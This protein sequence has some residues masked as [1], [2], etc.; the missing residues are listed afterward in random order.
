MEPIKDS[1][2]LKLKDDKYN[3]PESIIFC[4]NIY[5]YFYKN[6]TI[7]KNTKILNKY[8]KKNDRVDLEQLKNIMNRYLS[9]IIVKFCNRIKYYYSIEINNISNKIVDQYKNNLKRYLNITLNINKVYKNSVFKHDNKF[10]KHSNRGL[11]FLGYIAYLIVNYP[12]LTKHNKNNHRNDWFIIINKVTNKKCLD[13]MFTKK[14]Q[15]IKILNLPEI[16]Y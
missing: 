10:S 2:F 9:Q 4:D 14:T 3:C 7:S 11:L 1:C 5:D 15:V 16:M 12:S 8:Y 13:Y 6:H